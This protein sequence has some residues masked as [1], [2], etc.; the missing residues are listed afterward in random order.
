MTEPKLRFSHF[1]DRELSYFRYLVSYYED[2]TANN[3]TTGDQEESHFEGFLLDLKI[4]I[5]EEAQRRG[6]FDYQLP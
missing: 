2:V 1:L 3:K 6:M 4:E 5:D